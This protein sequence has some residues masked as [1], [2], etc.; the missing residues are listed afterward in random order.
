[1]VLA[2]HVLCIWRFA[3]TCWIKL[4]DYSFHYMPSLHESSPSFAFCYCW[5]LTLS[6]F[7]PSPVPIRQLPTIQPS[8]Q[9]WFFVEI[10]WLIFTYLS[11]LLLRVGHI[12]YC[13][14]ERRLDT[15]DV[16]TVTFTMFYH[17]YYFYISL[18]VGAQVR[19][20]ILAA[21]IAPVFIKLS[22]SSL[23]RQKEKWMFIWK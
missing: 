12:L 1:M 4:W 18:I 16:L 21:L 17:A 3:F 22:R 20:H 11:W 7:L 13:K 6:P 2:L 14:E 15:A 10:F 5:H 9:C 23:S 19:I 8:V